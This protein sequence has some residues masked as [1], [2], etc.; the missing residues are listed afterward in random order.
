MTDRTEQPDV[1][2]AYLDDDTPPWRRPEAARSAEPEVGTSPLAKQ[3]DEEGV[4]GQLA[5]RQ[6]AERRQ[7]EQ[8]AVEQSQ[9]WS[10]GNLHKAAAMVMAAP[11]AA[12]LGAGRDAI[13][14]ER[15]KGEMLGDWGKLTPE[16]AI[17]AARSE[18]E[19]RQWTAPMARSVADA[20]PDTTGMPGVAGGAMRIARGLFN[21][22]AVQQEKGLKHAEAM[23]RGEAAL[24][25]LTGTRA[26]VDTAAK[27]GADLF[28]TSW[29]KTAGAFSELAGYKDNQ[30]LE[31]GRHVDETVKELFPGD[32]AR[33]YEFTQQ[34]VQGAV[35]TGAFAGQNAL[36][37]IMG[38][39]KKGT[40]ALIAL[41][42]A[43]A[44][45]PDEFERVTKALKEGKATERDQLINTLAAAA[46]G[47]TEA[48][49]FVNDFAKGVKGWRRP[50]Y[51]GIE[52]GVEEIIQEGP[53]QTAGQNLVRKATYEPDQDPYEGVLSSMAVAGLSGAVFGGAAAGRGEKAEPPVREAKVR[54]GGTK[55]DVEPAAAADKPSATAQPAAERKPPEIDLGQFYPEGEAPKE[56][57]A[58]SGEAPGEP[59]TRTPI[60]E[61]A[62][63]A[64]EPEGMRVQAMVRKPGA[65]GRGLGDINPSGGAAAVDRVAGQTA[66]EGATFTTAKGSTYTVQPD[67]TTIRDKAARP[68]PGHEGQQGIQRQSEKTY[69]VT[70]ADGQRLAL[71]QGQSRIIDHGDGTLSV[72]NLNTGGPNA[73]KWGVSPDSRNIPVSTK[74]EVGKQPVELWRKEN[75]YGRDAYKSIHLGNDITEVREPAAQEFTTEPAA[76]APAVAVGD[77]VQWTNAGTDQFKEP[78]QVKALSPDGQWAFV[79]GAGTG[80][81]VAELTKAPPAWQREL[82]KQ[83]ADIAKPITPE[84]QAALDK[85][86]ADNLAGFHADIEA[87]YGEMGLD[88]AELGDE[89]VKS[90]AFHMAQGLTAEEALERYA[91]EK[92]SEELAQG[93]G[94]AEGATAGTATDSGAAGSAARTAATDSA[95]GNSTAARPTG[96]GAQRAGA[97]AAGAGRPAQPSGQP[98]RGAQQPAGSSQ[99]RQPGPAEREY[100]RALRARFRSIVFGKSPRKTWAKSLNVEP[101]KLKELIDEAVGQ[102]QLRIDR[103]GVVRR[104]ALARVNPRETRTLQRSESWAIPPDVRVNTRAQLR[105]AVTGKPTDPILLDWAHRL[106]AAIGEQS[107]MFPAAMRELKAASNSGQLNAAQVRE[108]ARLMG[109]GPPTIKA[110]TSKAEALASI[111]KRHDDLSRYVDGVEMAAFAGQ[112]AS[113]EALAAREAAARQHMESPEW[114]AAGEPLTDKSLYTKAGPARRYIAKDGTEIKGA[115]AAGRY[116]AAQAEAA[117]PGGVAREK[118]AILVIGHP[119]SGKSTIARAVSKTFRAA[120]MVSDIPKEIIPEYEGGKGGERVHDEASDLARLAVDNLMAKGDN[121]I[122]ETLGS[123]PKVAQRAAWLWSRGYEPSLVFIDTPKAVAMERALER[124]ERGKATG[125]A[126][127]VPASTFDLNPREAYDNAIAHEAVIEHTRVAPAENE[128]G[129]RTLEASGRFGADFQAALAEQSAGRVSGANGRLD[130][131][132][133]AA[134]GEGPELAAFA[135]RAADDVE[136]VSLLQEAIKD[137]LVESQSDR[138]AR[139]LSALTG[140]G[141]KP[142]EGRSQEGADAAGGEGTGGSRKLPVEGR[143]RARAI[144]RFL[145][146]TFGRSEVEARAKAQGFT[147][148]AFH[149]TRAPGSF[150]APEA[151]RSGHDFGFHVSLGTPRAAN[152][153]LGYP[154]AFLASLALKVAPRGVRR[155]LW[156]AGYPGS[157]LPLRL[158]VSN[159]LR[160]PDLGDWNDID[161]WAVAVNK[162]G[163]KGPQELRDWINNWTETNG[164]EH[165]VYAIDA[166]VSPSFSRAIAAELTRQGY[167]AVIYQNEVE[168][169]GVAEALKLVKNDSLF[170]WNPALVRSAHDV[171][172]ERATNDTGLM[173]SAKYVEQ[174][175]RE[176]LNR[177]LREEG[178]SDQEMFAFASRPYTPAF[179]QAL[180][181]WASRLEA[182][183]RRMLPEDVAVRVGDRLLVAPG[184]IAQRRAESGERGFAILNREE[185]GNPEYADWQRAHALAAPP[186][187]DVLG[188]KW[189]IAL[190][191]DEASGYRH[192]L[193]HGVHE[194]SHVIRE[195]SKD[196]MKALVAQGLRGADLLAALRDRGLWSKAEWKLLVDRANKIGMPQR[197]QEETRAPTAAEA[198]AMR[199]DGNTA[200]KTQDMLDTYAQFYN[201]RFAH[202][203]QPARAKL[204]D[205]YINQEL[206]SHMAQDFVAGRGTF[207]SKVDGLLSRIAKF[208]EA[209]RNALN[210]LGFRTADDVLEKAF[211]DSARKPV[212]GGERIEPT[213]G[214]APEM[215]AIAGPKAKNAPLSS[216]N[217]AESM[218]R[219]GKKAEDIFKQT[220]WFR[221]PDQMWRFEIDDSPAKLI[222]LDTHLKKPSAG[223]IGALMG[224]KPAGMPAWYKGN[225]RAATN[226]KLPDLLHHPKLFEAYPF[227][228]QMRV[229]VIV[230]KGVPDSREGGALVFRE[231]G[232]KLIYSP[233]QIRAKDQAGVLPTLVHELQHY[234]QKKEGFATGS[235][236]SQRKGDFE[237]TPL[238]FA[239]TNAGPITAKGESFSPG[240]IVATESEGG[241]LKSHDWRSQIAGMNRA[242]QLATRIADLYDSEDFKLPDAPHGSRQWARREDVRQ[243]LAVLQAQLMSALRVKTEDYVASLGEEEANL[244]MQRLGYTAE[245]RRRMMPQFS[246]KARASTLVTADFRKAA[247]AV[248]ASA[249]RTEAIRDK[250]RQPTEI[251]PGISVERHEENN[252]EFSSDWF[253]YDA[254][255]AHLD[256]ANG[257]GIIR[258]SDSALNLRQKESDTKKHLSALADAMEKAVREMNLFPTADKRL[259]LGRDEN[260][261][262][263][264]ENADVGRGESGG[265]EWA[266]MSDPEF[267]FWRARDPLFMAD[268]PRSYKDELQ[269]IA[270]EKYGKGS[271][272]RFHTEPDALT[273]ALE[274]SAREVAWPAD[275]QDKFVEHVRQALLDRVHNVSLDV[276][277][278]NDERR[279]AN[280]KVRRWEA[281]EK[282]QATLD[283]L[284]HQ[285]RS[286]QAGSEPSVVN[287]RDPKGRWHAL[288]DYSLPTEIPVP[289]DLASAGLDP[290]L[291][292]IRQGEHE[293]PGFEARE[294]A[295]APGWWGIYLGAEHYGSLGYRSREE[296]QQALREQGDL[297][298]SQYRNRHGM[299]G[300]PEMASFSSWMGGILGRDKNGGRETGLREAAAKRPSE[301][302]K[303]IAEETAAR[304]DGLPTAQP[305]VNVSRPNTSTPNL[306]MSLEARKARAEA[307]GFDTSRVLYHGTNRSFDVFSAV[308]PYVGGLNPVFL[309]TN[310]DQAGEYASHSGEGRILPVYLKRGRYWDW[311]N[312]A[313]V[314]SL[315]A[316]AR[317]GELFPAA[318]GHEHLAEKG[319][320]DRS[321]K[322]FAEGSPSRMME[323]LHA[324]PSLVGDWMRRQGYDGFVGLEH[325]DDVHYAVFAPPNIRSVNAAF[326]PAQESS[327]LL[328]ASFKSNDEGGRIEPAFRKEDGGPTYD[329]RAQGI[330]EAPRPIT[331]I[332]AD[333][334]Q[335][336]GMAVTQ[337]L[338]G[339]T[340]RNAETGYSRRIANQSGLAGQYQTP[341][342]VARIRASTDIATIAHEGGH[343]LEHLIGEPLQDIIA[344]NAAELNAYA[345]RLDSTTGATDPGWLSEG[346]A[347]FFTDYI[348]KPD[349]AQTSAPGFYAAFEDLLDAERPDILQNLDRLQLTTL[350]QDY[351]DYIKAT[352]VERGMADVASWQEPS[353]WEKT[354][355]FYR[356]PNK[357]DTLSQW[358]S[359]FSYELTDKTNPI[360]L[361][362]Q[363]LVRLADQNG[364]RMADG[365]PLTLQPGENAHRISRLMARA[366]KIGHQWILNGVPDY[367]GLEGIGP[368]LH[369]AIKLAV[370][371]TSRSQWTTGDDGTLTK[372]GLYLE[373]RR[374]VKEWER[375]ESGALERP[376]TRKSAEEYQQIIE[377]LDKANPTYAQAAAMVY[378]FQHRL[379]TLE[380]QAG[381]WTKA[382][383]DALSARKDYYVPFQRDLSDVLPTTGA[384]PGSAAAKKFQEQKAFKGS[385][386][387]IVN[388]L[389]AIAKRAY[390]TAAAVQFNDMVKSLTALSERV[391]LGGAG[392]IERVAYEEVRANNERTFELLKG[393]AVRAGMDEAD[394]HLTV[395][396]MEMN[397]QDTDVHLLWDPDNLGPMRPPI[398]PLWENG[399]RKLVRLNDPVMGRRLFEAMNALGREQSNIWIKAIGYP[400]A[401]LR[402]GVTMHPAFVLSNILGDMTAAWTLTGSITRPSSYPIVTQARGLYHLLS[403]NPTVRGALQKVGITP[404]D[405]SELYSRVGGISG[406]QNVAA[407]RA[408]HRDFDL[409]E[410][411]AKGYQIANLPAFGGLATTVAGAAAGGMVG[412]VVGA[413]L[414]ASVGAMVARMVFGHGAEAF[415]AQASE[416][417][418]TITRLGVAS[419]ALKRVKKLDPTLSDIDAIRE[420]AFTAS[421]VLDFDR[422]GAKAGT[423][424]KLIPF[425]NANIQGVSKAYRQSLV[426]DGERGKANLDKIGLFLRHALT[427]TGGAAMRERMSVRDQQAVADGM[428]AW[429]NMMILAG[430]GAALFLAFKDDP[431]YQDVGEDTKSTHF[432]FKLNGTW[433]RIKKPF[434]LAT[435]S[436]ITQSFLEWWIGKDPRLWGKI[437]DGLI[438]THAPPYLPQTIRTW[439]DLKSGID[440]RNDR[441]IV[442]QSLSRLPPF[443]QFDAYSSEFAMQWA[444]ALHV[445]G[446]DV[447][448]QKIDFAL[449]SSFGYWGREVQVSSNYFL[450]KNREA[451]KWT[452]LPIAG[453]MINRVTLDP[454]RR[455]AS[456]EEFW[457]AMGQGKG[458]FDQA[459]AGYDEALKSGNGSAVQAYLAGLPEPERIYAVLGQHF[460]ARDKE[461]HPLNRARAVMSID[462]AMRREMILDTLVDGSSRGAPEKI[463]LT[464]AKKTELHDILGRLSAI[465]TWNALHDLGIPGWGQREMRNP[466]VVL[467]EL[468][469]A[470]QPVYDEMMRRRGKEHV[471]DY[472]DDLAKWGEVKQRVVE[473]I[474]DDDML[475]QSWSKTVK[476]RRSPTP[477][478]QMPERGMQTPNFRIPGVMMKLGGPNLDAV[479][480]DEVRLKLFDDPKFQ[481][482]HEKQR[483]QDPES[484]FNDYQA[485]RS[486]EGM[487]DPFMH[488]FDTLAGR[489]WFKRERKSLDP[490]TL[491]HIENYMELRKR[492]FGVKPQPG[493]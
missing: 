318:T 416:L 433:V 203:A 277:A 394:A 242:E 155:R 328:M 250:W 59:G 97:T 180:P 1:D 437:K 171:F 145:D 474:N 116:L 338:H 41:T 45:V 377:D 153:R 169:A 302:G 172:D 291:W 360:L 492:R 439:A 184:D 264:G 127:A 108:L 486:D 447:S 407:L 89:D 349:Q 138:V 493:S 3:L 80:I 13:E 344:A 331:A 428:R 194:A 197:L 385:D 409:A 259:L 160:M 29:F 201:K 154:G 232:G 189:L 63:Q 137:G 83:L 325:G 109:F 34:L 244:V 484:R 141:R 167:D 129:W 445:M 357:W 107:F 20:I 412:G 179:R 411:R 90:V 11:V 364:V 31:Y 185:A 342:G 85:T 459:K 257:V 434:E 149:G 320:R 485:G 490:E 421:D 101:A 324:D 461:A 26:S 268:D 68:D 455:S 451:P 286:A 399:E 279:N 43:V 402:A 293:G 261:N 374:A 348:L 375:F 213:F 464:P 477:T 307:M 395:S 363:A 473:T 322:T 69:Y 295:T 393:Y 162:R 120:H 296:A 65:L 215:M 414:G 187:P 443:M 391:G 142:A 481:E 337:G 241:S 468:K 246:D 48:A 147:T 429:V 174:D 231:D 452:D 92:G 55:T 146:G 12:V 40:L 417:S 487:N 341:G 15:P 380:Y 139:F 98:Q 239:S 105:K 161:A 133:A 290:E 343:H 19:T 281:T 46:L 103:N 173:A 8:A 309:A 401:V 73:G 67:G 176:H 386:R 467:D 61:P 354:V 489:Q 227:L 292:K 2:Q 404:S 86:V 270:E 400:A 115:K 272:V 253:G 225:V 159:P 104:T 204:V 370:G 362:Q 252:L 240:T 346:F 430:V 458:S 321:L 183:L 469:A 71:P 418:E 219:K 74:P 475:G 470:S 28:Y 284:R 372:F 398:V 273:V 233:I 330:G 387:N 376:P 345:G 23:S 216:M 82:T 347:E 60:I 168:A 332:I 220:G 479:A 211:G 384:P 210:G 193:E 66:S 482:W 397:F 305:E 310:P 355:D 356:S 258:L 88:V 323:E 123:W 432:V 308:D 446:V 190:A 329:P 419:N 214:M 181:E 206:V 276:S 299:G 453:T 42:G 260:G 217:L 351:Q 438:Q 191:L 288:D 392:L 56:V 54:S 472:S 476:K 195:R 52:Q 463:P 170:V 313:D 352:A 306:D 199:R 373:A 229:N 121:V 228:N 16:Q 79:E 265:G 35:S 251:A 126:R 294:S 300:G 274:K 17:E 326:D 10:F 462:N 128:Q 140:E 208:F 152:S 122:I 135:D 388:P 425:M 255:R 106:E 282:G 53:V 340:V 271:V 130:R 287:I 444:K 39:G 301:S 327:S 480:E 336:L 38:L 78:A 96:P 178:I 51:K 454:S 25:T 256:Y 143:L 117:V 95:G 112:H 369:D 202:V 379:L 448:P 449:N 77:E 156:D 243:Q 403:T 4:F 114:K 87:A 371:G 317:S 426:L 466:D 110:K 483:Q 298:R 408:V 76:S 224:K 378:N 383:Y 366:D 235:N 57:Q 440:T 267:A 405:I 102:G 70:P 205:E 136:L 81:P 442:R 200:G 124:F 188:E 14:S 207:G 285:L 350:S 24:P 234:F 164:Y 420:A 358:M 381:K 118:K 21:A 22:E 49:P 365:R 361:S 196:A 450:G 236:T 125:N 353:L 47:A 359:R 491:R 192:A 132:G 237:V 209:M 406:G 37:Q 93:Q 157:M 94:S 413:T 144:D 456:V 304:A 9:G 7:A 186:R 471:G 158:K 315:R 263:V 221:G 198:E 177:A 435:I 423:L 27:T 297:L 266:T 58:G 62:A 30:L 280:A 278:A 50:L 72:A 222:N 91:V 319:Y 150:A 488:Y 163:Y 75:I 312:Q 84:Q 33:Q 367:D 151:F 113:K 166:G 249:A 248:A 148:V 478:I 99:Q 175:L 410:L 303:G 182:E 254:G 64:E 245:Q 441:P 415:F 396:Q 18:L 32:P 36:G 262:L 111:Q 390:Q 314:A 424:M 5:E 6:A 311:R 389:E 165:D 339:L 436:N 427:G 275:F 44:Q 316:A 226:I 289:A 431:E 119:G 247:D 230:G 368:S 457:K 333:L 422:N 334:K 335:A 134:E 460:K 465:E 218:E 269:T 382:Q 212:D 283:E 100:E 223:L 238:N 131:P